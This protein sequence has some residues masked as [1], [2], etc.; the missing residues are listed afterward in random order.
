MRDDRERLADILEA[1]EKIVTRTRRGRERVDADEDLQ[2]VLT[3]DYFAIDLD[4]L[5]TASARDI[6]PLTEQ[7]RAV[8]DQHPDP[9]PPN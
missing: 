4:I 7:I 8:L 9:A 2:L 1:A 5:W 3:H 6:P